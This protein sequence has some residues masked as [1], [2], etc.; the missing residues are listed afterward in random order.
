MRFGHYRRLRLVK[1]QSAS[2]AIGGLSEGER[3]RLRL[4]LLTMRNNGD[5]TRIRR[6]DNVHAL[7]VN[8][9]RSTEVDGCSTTITC[10]CVRTIVKKI[11]GC[12]NFRDNIRFYNFAV[13]IIPICATFISFSRENLLEF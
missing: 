4:H 11:R 7:G 10:A 9:D 5:V 8:N 6:P 2:L 12:S 1:R 3:K 13:F